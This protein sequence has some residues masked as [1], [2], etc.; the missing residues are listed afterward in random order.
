MR[1]PVGT[2]TLALAGIC[3]NLELAPDAA[4]LPGHLPH[5]QPCTPEDPAVAALAPPHGPSPCPAHLQTFGC[6]RGSCS[7]FCSVEH[8]GAFLLQ[9]EAPLRRTEA[10]CERK[11]HGL[12]VVILASPACASPLSE[13]SH[14]SPCLHAA[15]SE[16]RDTGCTGLTS[17]PTSSSR[18]QKPTQRITTKP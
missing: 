8:P 14:T 6:G 9:N 15:V 1:S 11:K 10:I 4:L 13:G 16:I 7:V 5:S 12:L 3:S 17:P 18:C 2:M